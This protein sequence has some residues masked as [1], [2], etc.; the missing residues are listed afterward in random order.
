MFWWRQGQKRLSFLTLP[1]S[2]QLTRGLLLLLLFLSPL[3]PGLFSWERQALSPP[4]T[5][6]MDQC[7]S[8]LLL[9]RSNTHT[10]CCYG[11]KTPAF[12]SV[13]LCLSI[14]LRLYLSVSPIAIH[15][16]LSGGI[17]LPLTICVS[18]SGF[19]IPPSVLIH[20]IPVWFH[21]SSFFAFFWRYYTSWK[22]PLYY[23]F[24]FNY[25][26]ACCL[27]LSLC[28]SISL[29]ISLMEHLPTH[30]FPHS[31]PLLTHLSVHTCQ[32]AYMWVCVCVFVCASLHKQWPMWAHL[33]D[34]AAALRC[35]FVCVFW[36]ASCQEDHADEKED[37]SSTSAAMSFLLRW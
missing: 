36:G 10:N 29:S 22:L 13:N 9:R 25:S 24:Y 31:C 32:S 4:D 8:S 5:T 2:T 26:L 23:Y 34:L 3:C 17:C 19:T 1:P 33:S 27:S 11:L 7:W 6:S 15:A 28:I 30:T 20:L 16:F 14:C 35:V 21:I 12:F 18:D 37:I